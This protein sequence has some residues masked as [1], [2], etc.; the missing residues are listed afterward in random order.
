M[1]TII[2]T[3]VREYGEGDPVELA[4]DETSC[5]LCIRASVDGGFNATAVDLLDLIA[6]LKTNRPD[7]L[8]PAL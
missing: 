3:G 8:A 7:L 1:E 5:R 6:W 4:I 2:L